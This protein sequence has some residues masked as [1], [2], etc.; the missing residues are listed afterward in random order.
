MKSF[1]GA[2]SENKRP[3]RLS[4]PDFSGRSFSLDD[5]A[6]SWECLGHGGDLLLLGTGP[7]NLGDLPF[8]RQA[9]REKRKIFWLDCPDTLKLLEASGLGRKVLPAQAQEVDAE[10][11]LQMARNLQI[12]FYRP[13][14]RLSPDWWGSLLGKILAVDLVRDRARQITGKRCLP[15]V[16]LPGGG[17]QLL[18]A[19][20]QDALGQCGFKAVSPGLA[21]KAQNFPKFLNTLKKENGSLPEFFLSVNL[22]GLDAGGIV[23]NICR[24]LGIQVALWLVDNPWHLLSSIRLPWWKKAHIFVTDSSFMDALRD[25]G[26]ENVFFLPL[27]TARHMWRP[28]EDRADVGAPLFVGRAAFPE[29]DRFF[30]AARVPPDLQTEA[31]LR[32]VR[33]CRPEETP[34]FHW[35]LRK[36]KISPWPGTGVRVAGLGAENCSRDNRTR[37]LAAGLGQ[38]L[39]IVGGEEWK[40]YLPECR[41]LPPVDYYGDLP[42]LYARAA[43]VLNVTSLLLPA[44]LSQRHF[45][46]W[47]AGGYLLSD[48]TAGLDI[49][50]EY[51]RRETRLDCPHDLPDALHEMAEKNRRNREIRLAWREELRKRHSYA[52]RISEICARLRIKTEAIP[53]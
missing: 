22:R 46:V 26:A 27:A 32:L 18:H 8:V 9:I 5:S 29:K 30:A 1:N 43:A 38:G 44:S 51:L 40:A 47:A 14:L 16:I 21:Q 7:G 2:Y 24:S 48:A 17:H 37:W 52:H 15:A 36:L 3:K 53:Q 45:D 50:P 10:H 39:A 28:L 34:N 23:F 11:C 20:L 6:T 13:G 33:S 35:W 42:K 19:E 25:E 31:E 49:F 12:F 4:L 41:P